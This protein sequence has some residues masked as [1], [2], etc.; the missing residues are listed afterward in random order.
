MLCD[1]D[2]YGLHHSKKGGQPMLKVLLV[3]DEFIVRQGLKALVNWEEYGMKVIADTANGESEL[4]KMNQKSFDI[5]ITDI[6][7][8]IID[9]IELT[10]IIME[11]Y[12]G[13]K[14]I[15]LTCYSDFEFVKE[16]LDL[17]ASGYLL[18]TD[19]EDGHLEKTLM[20]IKKEFEEKRAI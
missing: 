5:V 4:E 16:A 8:A 19:M 15:L 18:K 12:P 13:T 20:K 11:R 1:L 7:M 10:R 14:V 2:D 17:G 3:D 6:R 9:G